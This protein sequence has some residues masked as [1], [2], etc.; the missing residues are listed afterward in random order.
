M[1]F[2]SA[3]TRSTLTDWPSS[4]S[5][6]V[7][8]GPRVNP[9]TWASTSNCSSTLETASTMRSLARGRRGGGGG[10]GGAG[11]GR[12]ARRGGGG[13]GGG[14]GGAPPPGPPGGGGGAGRGAGGGSV[15]DEGGSGPR[16]GPPRRC[17]WPPAGGAA[18]PAA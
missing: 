2:D 15:G 7:T 1:F 9:V 13:G 17:L 10:G 5:Y 3:V 11:G 14:G 16:G 18:R 8:V 12:G 4:I 6:L